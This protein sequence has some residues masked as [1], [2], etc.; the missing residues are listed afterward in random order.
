[1]L[2]GHL[3][4]SL[5]RGS[6][7]QEDDDDDVGEGGGEV[8][9]L[10]TGLDPLE[11]TEEVDQPGD[12]ETEKHPPRGISKF[13]EGTGLAEHLVVEVEFRGGLPHVRGEGEGL[14]DREVGAGAGVAIAVGAREDARLP[15]L[16]LPTVP[17]G[18]VG[19]NLG[20]DENVCILQPPLPRQSRRR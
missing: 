20:N 11:E 1:M 14:R 17:S 12:P 16:C 15:L 5:K 2:G 18:C 4:S 7:H 9:D 13:G 10:A 8:D 6:P 19:Q 3:V